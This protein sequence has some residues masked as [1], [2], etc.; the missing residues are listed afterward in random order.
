M[1]KVDQVALEHFVTQQHAWGDQERST[2]E[3]CRQ[4]SMIAEAIA[5]TR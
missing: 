4:G 3:S 1:Q 2:T 5:S